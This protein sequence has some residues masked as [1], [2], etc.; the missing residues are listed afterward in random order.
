[1]SIRIFVALFLL[2]LWTGIA[3]A[4]ESQPYLEERVEAL[5]KQVRELNERLK[6]MEQRPTSAPKPAYAVPL[7]EVNAPV[8]ALVP[9]W[10]TGEGWKK[11][12]L[13]MN[14]IQVTQLLGN[15]A[16]RSG[17]RYTERWHYPDDSAWV[18]FDQAGEI[19]GWQSPVAK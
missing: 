10:Q 12:R 16:R 14:Q 2:G 9:G 15:P 11:L 18:E 7:D 6:Q 5:E 19:S 13:G 3:G 4:A 1:M 8:K 17:D